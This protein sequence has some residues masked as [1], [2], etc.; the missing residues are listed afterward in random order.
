MARRLAWSNV[1]GGLVAIAVIIGICVATL[2][3]ARVGALR[4]ERLHLYAVMGAAR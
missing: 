1:R 4:G 2:K 3:Y